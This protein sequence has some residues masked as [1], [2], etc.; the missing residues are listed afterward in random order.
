MAELFQTFDEDDDGFIDKFELVKTY[1]G[2]GQEIDVARAE[3]MIA[4]VD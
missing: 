1:Q 3:T 2:L 4:Q